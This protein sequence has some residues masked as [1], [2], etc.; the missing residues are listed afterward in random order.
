MNLTLLRV[1]FRHG[2]SLI[3]MPWS[4]TAGNMPQGLQGGKQGGRGPSGSGACWWVAG[5]GPQH[6][7]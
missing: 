1:G 6:S 7:A 5:S 2:A 4:P 3:S